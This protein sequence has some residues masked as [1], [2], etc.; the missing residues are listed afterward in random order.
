MQMLVAR[1]AR[2]EAIELCSQ[3]DLACEEALEEAREL[4]K[5]LDDARNELRELRRHLFFRDR[6]KKQRK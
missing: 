2:D 5:M 1:D 4:R 6:R 3:L